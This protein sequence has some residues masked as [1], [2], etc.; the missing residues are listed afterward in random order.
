M[1]PDRLLTA[2]RREVI[3]G[4]PEEFK[5]ACLRDI[6]RLFGPSN[7]YYAGFGNRITVGSV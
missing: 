4:R 1:S 6:L 7:P 3:I 2:F 5:I